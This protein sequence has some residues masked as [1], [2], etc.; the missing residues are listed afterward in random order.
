VSLLLAFSLP[1]HL[2]LANIT[3]DT[4]TGGGQIEIEWRTA[5]E[6]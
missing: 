3:K 4:K 1:L 5:G 2:A 6:F